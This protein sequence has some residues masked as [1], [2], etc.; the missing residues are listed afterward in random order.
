MATTHSCMT[1]H[2]LQ[3][4]KLAT[5]TNIGQPI[6]SI[7]TL[8]ADL[9]LYQ[10]MLASFQQAGFTSTDC[11]FLWLDNSDNNQWDAYR[12]IQRF[13]FEAR[14]DYIIVCHQDIL[15]NHDRRE[16]LERCITELEQL[17]PDW[18]LI[19]NAGG[20]R[21]GKL[22]HR[23]SDPHGG[24]LNSGG[25]PQRVQSLDENFILL[26]R[27]ANPGISRD[28]QGFHMYGL[29]LCLQAKLRGFH[30]YVV[31]FHLTHLGKGNRD[32]SF[33]LQRDA[34]ISKYR[35]A[36]SPSWL[37]TTCTSLFISGSH[38]LNQWFNRPTLIKWAKSVFKRRHKDQA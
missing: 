18:G 10:Q 6:Y 30:A 21:L 24:N 34:L 1:T 25:F 22:V 19:G 26:K 23:I 33:Y 5:S 36:F 35:Q 27:A 37:Q 31:D 16:Q 2:P 20:I 4:R 17:D 29:D 7:C 32:K 38:L 3:A 28:L 13:L 12:G 15:L 9:S 8:V 11:E 14:G